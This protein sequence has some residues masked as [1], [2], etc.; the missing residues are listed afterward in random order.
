MNRWVIILALGLASISRVASGQQIYDD[1][2]AQEVRPALNLIGTVCTQDSPLGNA[3]NCTVGGGSGNGTAD[4]FFSIT[5]SVSSGQCMVAAAA[6]PTAAVSCAIASGSSTTHIIPIDGVE[7][8]IAGI[9]CW[10]ADD[11]NIGGMAAGESITFVPVWVPGDGSSFTGTDSTVTTNLSFNDGEH[12]PY[13]AAD[14]FSTETSPYTGTQGLKLRMDW[15]GTVSPNQLACRVVVTGLAGGG[16]GGG[17]GGTGHV[18]QDEGTPQPTQPAL[19][20]VG[21]GVTCTD[22]GATTQCAVPSIGGGGD[23]LIPIEFLADQ[24]SDN[25][26]MRAHFRAPPNSCVPGNT[27]LVANLTGIEPSVSPSIIGL[28]CWISGSAYTSFDPGDSITFVPTWIQ[29]DTFGGITTTDSTTTVVFTD[30]DNDPLDTVDNFTADTSPYTGSQALR[31]RTDIVGTVNTTKTDC[32]ALIDIGAGGSSGHEIQYIG[33][34]LPTEPA[35]NFTNG[36]FCAD[37]PGVATVCEVNDTQVMTQNIYAFGLWADSPHIPPLPVGPFYG[38]DPTTVVD[39]ADV[40]VSSKGIDVDRDGIFEITDVPGLSLTFDIDENG[41]TEIAGTPTSLVLFPNA[42]ATT[43]SDTGMISLQGEAAIQD[44]A[45]FGSGASL[46]GPNVSCAG[47]ENATDRLFNDRN[48]NYATVQTRDVGPAAT[49]AFA[50][51]GG[52]E[53]YLENDNE[54]LR[55]TTDFT[56]TT[57]TT[58]AEVTGLQV[59]VNGLRTYDITYNLLVQSTSASY[60]TTGAAFGVNYTNGTPVPFQCIREVPTNDAVGVGVTGIEENI[61]TGGTTGKAMEFWETQTESSGTPDMGPTTGF[62]AQS[63]SVLQTIHCIMTTIV[64]A[65]DI[66]LWVAASAANNIVVKAQ[67]WVNVITIQ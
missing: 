4:L 47:R 29:G 52:I 50:T 64:G 59:S 28:T 20:F 54:L 55:L 65:G 63:S 30:T 15:T 58:G 12:L 39:S 27:D 17:G 22:V 6:P 43:I 49:G 26:C 34:P 2:V 33:T 66:E 5:S 44:G 3:N 21:A 32:V 7:P 18:I 1:G 51:T 62:A 24:L 9:S 35:L 13:V 16:G 57:G 53:R 11:V 31:I 60:A 10:N 19:N 14:N 40:A 37:N 25:N 67:S 38:L 48:C 61:H 36:L 45:R 8:E 23:E 41:V 46:T 56:H 42:T